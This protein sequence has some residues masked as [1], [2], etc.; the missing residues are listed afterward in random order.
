MCL[1]RRRDGD[2]GGV[3]TTI[4]TG[5]VAKSD[6]KAEY[7]RALEKGNAIISKI[8]PTKISEQ[9]IEDIHYWY[10]YAANILLQQ[11]EVPRHKITGKLYDD[12]NQFYGE[13]HIRNI[14]KD[15]GIDLELPENGNNS[16]NNSSLY[17][18]EQENALE[19][20]LADRMQTFLNLWKSILRTQAWAS[21]RDPKD[22]QQSL[23]LS[24]AL[25]GMA[26]QSLDGRRL[27]QTPMAPLLIECAL[28]YTP[29]DAYAHFLDRVKDIAKKTTAESKIRGIRT[30]EK[31]TG[32][33]LGRILTLNVKEVHESA[34][35]VDEHE[36]RARGFSGQKCTNCGSLRCN[37]LNDSTAG[38]WY[39]CVPCEHTF[40]GK[41]TPGYTR[42]MVIENAVSTHGPS[43]A[44][45]KKKN[46]YS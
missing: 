33:E 37:R 14:L 20:Q 1:R 18:H 30:I 32:K 36:A 3:L 19:L 46:G 41:I 10:R 28:E 40:E 7:D 16:E 5:N 25:Y 15:G 42:G 9:S 11:G 39:K 23:A 8:S 44:E 17:T 26:I 21:L 29:Q 45:W 6:L 12:F 31:I 2:G 34:D 13:R 38:R 4:L 35:P 22:R 24:N 43:H 27:V